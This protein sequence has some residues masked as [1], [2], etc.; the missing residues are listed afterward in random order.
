VLGLCERLK[1]GDCPPR[2]LAVRANGA[3]LD[4]DLAGLAQEDRAPAPAPANGGAA[5]RLDLLAAT[6]GGA[7]NVVSLVVDLAEPQGVRELDDNFVAMHIALAQK[8]VYGR[9][10]PKATGIVVQL[11]HTADLPL[12]RDRLR[13]L[14]AERHLD[15]EVRGFA[16]LQSRI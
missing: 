8:L 16:E 15:L 6:A 14:F 1:I 13:A 3:R 5:P 12:A 2:P 10:P 11:R 9:A 7:P 4:G